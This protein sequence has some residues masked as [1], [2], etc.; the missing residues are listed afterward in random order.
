MTGRRVLPDHAFA[1]GVSGAG[2]SLAT[3][4]SRVR[5]RWQLRLFARAVAI[6]G[7]VFAL[8]LVLSLSAFAAPRQTGLWIAVVA[9]AGAAVMFAIANRRWS[10][11]DAAKAIERTAGSLDTNR[12]R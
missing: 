6:G 9:G 3:T 11:L 12:P 4:L 8:A 7:A 10:A 5:R 2:N 1:N